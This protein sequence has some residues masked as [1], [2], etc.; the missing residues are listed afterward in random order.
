MSSSDSAGPGEGAPFSLE[1]LGSV[2]AS[3]WPLLLP[4]HLELLK[5]LG[6]RGDQG[7][8]PGGMQ[9]GQRYGSWGHWAVGSGILAALEVAQA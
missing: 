5:T 6:G 9:V 4:P 8:G 7:G 3:C 2:L 1:G